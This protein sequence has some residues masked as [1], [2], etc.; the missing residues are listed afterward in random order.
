MGKGVP[1]D[2]LGCPQLKS[3][4]NCGNESSF[5]GEMRRQYRNLEGPNLLLRKDDCL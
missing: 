4:N 2:D 1:G 3:V 5:V